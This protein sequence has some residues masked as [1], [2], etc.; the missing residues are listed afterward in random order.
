MKVLLFKENFNNRISL[1]DYL[2]SAGLIVDCI[3][4]V[5]SALS[6]IDSGYGF[7]VIIICSDVEINK[8]ILFI[9]KLRRE[10][11]SGVPILFLSSNN[12]LSRK[13]TVFNL[14]VD[15]FLSEP[16]VFEE[17]RLRLN[18]LAVRGERRDLAEIS[19]EGLTLNIKNDTLAISGDIIKLTKT[20]ARIIKILLVKSPNVVSRDELL[21][22]VWGDNPTESDALRSHIYALRKTLNL[23][24]VS[25]K[26]C[27]IKGLG[28]QL[29]KYEKK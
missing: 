9:N 23:N 11:I 15:D 10:I 25:L 27:T 12:D 22:Y 8:S 5:S 21:D 6:L 19:Y 29:I 28:Y 14:G 18:A 20:H 1:L 7:D 13:I 16:F 2:E 4:S 3:Y 26:L 24:Y 17:I